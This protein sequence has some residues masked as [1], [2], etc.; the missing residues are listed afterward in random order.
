MLKVIKKIE[1]YLFIIDSEKLE[2]RN[3]RTISISILLLLILCTALNPANRRNIYEYYDLYQT[4]LFHL[5]LL[6][7]L[8]LSLFLRVYFLGLFFKFH[9]SHLSNKKRFYSVA[10]GMWPMIIHETLLFFTIIEPEDDIWSMILRY[11][12]IYI[13]LTNLH[14]AFK[15]S[16]TKLF[17]NA[18]SAWAAE[19]ITFY[20]LVPFSF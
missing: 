5:G 14:S 2:D 19:I 4:A 11:V 10:F 8:A 7:S 15:I 13:A 6:T 9:S 16:Y 20:V 3:F 18:T 12:C 17:L 1:H